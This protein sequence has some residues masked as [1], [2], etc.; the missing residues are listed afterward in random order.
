MPETS[1][2][3]DSAKK[4]IQIKKKFDFENS[5]LNTSFKNDE[6]I[7]SKCFN[8]HAPDQAKDLGIYP[9]FREIQETGSSHVVIDGKRVVTIS[10][11]NYLGLAKDPSVI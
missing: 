4:I 1:L 10:S 2:D 11:N 9:Y 7:L 6:N 3:S 8:Y 5:H